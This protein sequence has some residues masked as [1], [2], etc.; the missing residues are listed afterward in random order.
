M[1]VSWRCLRIS[2]GA[3]RMRVAS[4]KSSGYFAPL[5]T[6]YSSA[7]RSKLI[8]D[9]SMGLF[10]GKA[11]YVAKVCASPKDLCRVEGMTTWNKSLQTLKPFRSP[12]RVSCRGDPR[13]YDVK[14]ACKRTDSSFVTSFISLISKPSA[15]L[16]AT[17]S[18]SANCGSAYESQEVKT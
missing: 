16:S 13:K 3:A 7:M 9:S 1:I 4:I 2:A 11:G 15:D 12:R 8:M 14:I 6:S 10:A 18:N 5:A 17:L